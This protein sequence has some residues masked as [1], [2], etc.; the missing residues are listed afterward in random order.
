LFSFFQK[1]VFQ[2]FSLE[3]K[4]IIF[5]TKK[6][7]KFFEFYWFLLGSVHLHLLGK[8]IS[9]TFRFTLTLCPLMSALDFFYCLLFWHWICH[10]VFSTLFSSDIDFTIDFFPPFS[11]QTLNL[12]LHF[13]HIDTIAIDATFV[14]FLIFSIDSEMP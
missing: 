6:L 8:T 1:I 13:F 7:P 12:L 3:R 10:L 9:W 5:Y 11:R 4:D 2:S 14:L